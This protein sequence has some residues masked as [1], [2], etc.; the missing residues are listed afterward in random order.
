[1]ARTKKVALVLIPCMC[2]SICWDKVYYTQPELPT[3]IN[4]PPLS[5]IIRVNGLPVVLIVIY[6]LSCNLV[7]QFRCVKYINE[8]IENKSRLLL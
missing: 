3:F 1:M 7:C 4:A 5:L 2:P 6:S 8:Q